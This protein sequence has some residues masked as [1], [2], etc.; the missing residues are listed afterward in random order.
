MKTTVTGP[1]QVKRTAEQVHE[2]MTGLLGRHALD[3]VYSGDLEGVGVGE[4]LSAGGTVPGSAGYVA[5]EKVTGVLKGLAGSFYIQHTGV[6]DRGSPSLSI[7]VIPD[8]GTDE[9][10][11]LTGDMAIV[12]AP[13]GAHSYEFTY[14]II[15]R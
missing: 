12:I 15:A 6:M 5:I 13:G 11:G 3:K 7:K 8:T 1:F 9:L 14:E 4:M 10:A 2:A